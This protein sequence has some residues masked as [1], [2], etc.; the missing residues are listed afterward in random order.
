MHET[1][2]SMNLNFEVSVTRFESPEAIS[3]N[4]YRC[5]AISSI[6]ALLRIKSLEKV[7]VWVTCDT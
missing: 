6:A 1:Q 2:V 5:T 4:F 7:K 3:F